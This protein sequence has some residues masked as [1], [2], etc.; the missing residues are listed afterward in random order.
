[1]NYLTL[2]KLEIYVKNS[3]GKYWKDGYRYRW[4]Y[5]GYVIE[6]LKTMNPKT[7]CEA[8]ANGVLL[9]KESFSMD[10]PDYDLNLIPYPFKDKQFD[11]FVALQV[12]EHLNKRSEAF[13][14]VTRIS[15]AAI[16][17]FPYE[18]KH[19]DKRHRNIDWKKI[20][21]WTCGIKPVSTKLISDRIVYI[22]KFNQ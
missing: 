22:W 9:C 10:L 13:R 3:I 11:C 12:W 17:S 18:W 16:L 14:E 4:K 6:Q 7:I 15:K 21:K 20:K 19:G 2:K 1:M 8:G 5:M